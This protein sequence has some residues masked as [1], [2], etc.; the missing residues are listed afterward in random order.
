MRQTGFFHILTELVQSNTPTSAMDVVL[1]MLSRR[2]NF[3]CQRL[4]LLK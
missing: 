2:E 1:R 4:T 3:F